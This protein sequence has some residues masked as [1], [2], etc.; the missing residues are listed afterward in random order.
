[1]SL[2]VRY[3]LSV[4]FNIYSIQIKWIK[5]CQFHVNSVEANNIS[6]DLIFI[7]SKINK[8]YVKTLLKSTEVSSVGLLCFHVGSAD[9]VILPNTCNYHIK[10]KQVG[11]GVAS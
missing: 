2:I 1:M 7:Y 5:G 3:C 6:G 8:Q 9:T 10:R 4:L 11:Y